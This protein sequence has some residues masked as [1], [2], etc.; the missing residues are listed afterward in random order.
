MPHTISNDL[1]QVDQKRNLDAA[2]SRAGMISWLCNDIRRLRSL[3]L[4]FADYARLG[5]AESARIQSL[6]LFELEKA[7]GNPPQSEAGT[8]ESGS[9][10]PA[11]EQRL[12]DEGPSYLH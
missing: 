2:V 9:M 8:A 5:P 1:V 10:Q 12:I 7:T 11:V 4:A 6:S 3:E